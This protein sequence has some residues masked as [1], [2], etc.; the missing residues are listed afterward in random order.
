ML[1]CMEYDQEHT[2][3]LELWFSFGMDGQIDALGG[4]GFV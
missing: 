1:I 4:I 3:S 2:P